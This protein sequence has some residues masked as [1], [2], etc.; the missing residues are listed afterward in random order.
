MLPLY[1]FIYELK[2][3]FVSFF[4]SNEARIRSFIT[5]ISGFVKGFINGIINVF[6][7]IYN[8]VSFLW[9]WREVLFAVAGGFAVLNYQ[10]VL[11]GISTGAWA[12]KNAVLTA[13]QWALNIAMN[14]NPIGIII[15]LISV[16]IGVIAALCRRYQGWVTVW[17]AVKTTLV[18][19]FKQFVSSWKLGFQEIWF[20]IR[21]IWKRL[22]SFGQFAS[23]LFLNI[24]KA[25]KAALSGNFSEAKQI[26][27][28]NI[29]TEASKEIER[30]KQ[31][32][33]NNRK[34]YFSESVENIK[35]TKQAW[36]NVSLTKKTTKE[37]IDSSPSFSSPLIPS[38]DTSEPSSDISSSFSSAD[39]TASVT[40]SAKQIRNI[41]INIDSFIKGGINT[42]NTEMQHMQAPEIASYLEDLLMRVI[43]NV[44]MSY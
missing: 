16:L 12:V 9:S 42:Q 3:R 34:K 36:Q 37:Q 11:A 10:T 19:S 25:V 43:R 32:R 13:S 2:S 33:E 18:N 29:T 41:T 8:V 21:I 23:Q 24:G 26:L 5:N 31:E 15:T 40:G 39:A 27:T 28:S 7:G 1:Q 20:E 44:E 14:A 35:Q 17:N 30:L 38:S 4:Q 6:K 22:Q